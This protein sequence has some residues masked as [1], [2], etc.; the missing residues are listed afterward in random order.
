MK[1]NFNTLL[2]KTVLITGASSGLGEAIAYESVKKG[3][4]VILCARRQSEL[5]R[6]TTNCRRISQSRV[7]SIVLDVSSYG[8]CQSLFAVLTRD[9]LR[10]DVLVNCAGFGVF[11]NFIDTPRHTIDQM[12]QV[13]VLGL[14]HLTQQIALLMIEQGTGHIINIAS[15]AGKM[16]TP[17]SSIYSAT[18]FAIIGFS[19]SLRLELRDF[20]IA[21]TTVNP[22][23]IKTNFFKIADPKGNYLEKVGVLAISPESLAKKI[24]DSMGSYR[25]EINVPMIMELGSKCY[26]LFPVVGDA[27]AR[28]V[29]N[30]K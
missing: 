5:E 24:V 13:N 12:F 26:Q 25:R 19:N 21:V 27:L 28:T 4:D 30:K 17:K 29:F 7:V 6:V 2:N 1:K 22:G 11:E 8:S 3:A 18:K 9:N 14:I 23:P 10:V 15:Q 16:A 20:G